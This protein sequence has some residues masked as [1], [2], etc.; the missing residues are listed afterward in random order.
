MVTACKRNNFDIIIIVLGAGTKTQRTTDTINLINYA[1]QNFE[2]YDFKNLINSSFESF[3][4]DHSTN[5]VINKTID[6]PIFELKNSNF[7]LPIRKNEIG[8]F[9]I[10]T[11][12]LNY[13]DSPIPTD[14]KIGVLQLYVNNTPVLNIDITIKNSI[15]KTNTFTYFIYILKSITI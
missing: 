13:I 3:I 11:Y 10:S 4:N 2:I 8:N 12:H 5:I 14:F 1:Y 15:S 9:K 6:K 7:L